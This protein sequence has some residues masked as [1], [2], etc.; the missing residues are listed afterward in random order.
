[1]LASLLTQMGGR[2][3]LRRSM[4]LGHRSTVTAGDARMSAG[5]PGP[6]RSWDFTE[7]LSFCSVT[8]AAAGDCR[9]AQVAN[10]TRCQAASQLHGSLMYV[11][12]H[13]RV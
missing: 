6:P 10:T 5:L 12:L 7:T 8:P 9:P 13:S 11:R 3:G 1:M 2:P 4:G